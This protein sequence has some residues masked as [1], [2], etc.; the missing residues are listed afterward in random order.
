MR[1]VIFLVWRCFA[2][3]P[4]KK[5]YVG[6]GEGIAEFSPFELFLFDKKGIFWSAPSL[7]IG[8]R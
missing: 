4:A 6:E 7:Y 5:D 3:M 1:K 2:P 8:P